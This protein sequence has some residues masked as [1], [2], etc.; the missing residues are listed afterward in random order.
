MKIQLII[1]LLSDIETLK[2]TEIYFC[3][4]IIFKINK[5]HEEILKNAK[6]LKNNLIILVFI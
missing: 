1:F 2:D 5:N 4:L 3:F 6:D